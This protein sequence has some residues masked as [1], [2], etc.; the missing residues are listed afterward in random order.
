MRPLKK[1]WCYEAQ[2]LLSNFFPPQ[3]RSKST[4]LSLENWSSK[5][6]NSFNLL[7]WSH[8]QAWDITVDKSTNV[9]RRSVPEPSET[10]TSI[11]TLQNLIIIPNLITPYN[12]TRNPLILKIALTPRMSNCNQRTKAGALCVC[13]LRCF[14][15][16]LNY[17]DSYFLFWLIIR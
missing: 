12:I 7:N 9:T 15:L 4:S 17:F 13:V 2:N 11:N 16:P 10:P 8:G 5:T 1:H 3:F 6:R 14:Q